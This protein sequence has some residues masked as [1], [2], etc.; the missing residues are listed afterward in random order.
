MARRLPD[1][2]MVSFELKLN[3]LPIRTCCGKLSVVQNE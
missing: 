1:V 2:W 3:F